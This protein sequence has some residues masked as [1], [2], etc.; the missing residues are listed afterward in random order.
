VEVGLEPACVIVC[1][2]QAIVAGDLDDER[3][4]IAR[5][6]ASQQTQV[7]KPEQGTQP[8]LF[9]L[10]AEAAALTP[11]RQERPGQYVFAQSASIP[12][13]GGPARAA[14]PSRTAPGEPVDLL[15]MARAVYDVAR[16]PAP[17]GRKVSAYL[18][19]KSVAAGT[20]LLASLGTILGAA[21]G[22]P[23]T[24]IVAPA[25]AL[26]FLALTTGL[27]VLDLRRPG[28][29]LYL[30]LKP[31]W[32][33]WLVLGGFVLIAFG[34]F[35]ASWLAAG[36]AGRLDALRLLAWPTLLIAAAAAGYSA[37]LFGQAEGRDFWQSSLVLPHLLAAAVVAGAAALLLAALA[38]GDDRE[39]IG[40]FRV[41]LT[42]GLAG[43]GVLLAAELF[44]SHPT[45]DAARSAA[46]LRRGELAGLLWGGVGVAGTL[47]PLVLLGIPLPALWALA[48]IL[49]LAGLWL[50]E[51]LWIRAG[52]AVPLS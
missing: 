36:W 27:L 3:A 2:V 43:S 31:N 39:A 11:D 16:P 34:A 19:T 1:P 4:P 42:V 41:L 15:G 17:W 50:Y 8:K 38:I 46:L 7:R 12:V 6:V 25:L 32:R 40:A 48:A 44:G 18:W 29:F 30:L 49:A 13:P 47:A 20:L 35:A 28:R 14:A 52:Q 5:L 26:A 9:Y 33:S 45:R 21:G 24:G 37:F 22:G 10:G 51:D 23:L